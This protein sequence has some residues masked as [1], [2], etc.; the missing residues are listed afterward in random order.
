MSKQPR[1]YKSKLIPVYKA[2]GKTNVTFTV[3]HSGTYLIYEDKKL[4]YVG[5]S[6]NNMYRTCMRHFNKWS[7]TD[8]LAAFFGFKAG[9]TYYGNDMSRYKV[10]FIFCTAERAAKLEKSLIIKYNPRDNTEKYKSYTPTPEAVELVN[11]FETARI[12][13]F[14]DM[15]EAPF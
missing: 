10:R 4:V 15:E 13:N 11:E 1:L 9:V 14:D 6:S 12:T 7:D 5:Y 2:P 8:K 3:G